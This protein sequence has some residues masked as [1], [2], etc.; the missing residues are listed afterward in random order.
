MITVAWSLSYEM[1]YYLAIPLLIGAVGLR[2][3]NVKW[4]L[5]FFALMALAMLVAGALGGGPVRLVMFV[6]GIVLFE[7]VKLSNVTAPSAWIGMMALVL[8]LLS[9]LLLLFGSAGLALRMLFLF[10]AF[11]VLCLACFKDGASWLD[12]LFGW[13]PLR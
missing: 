7:V 6:A 13:T 11:F 2:D 5:G 4:R 3:R 10:V 12:R 1:F 9:T 8:G